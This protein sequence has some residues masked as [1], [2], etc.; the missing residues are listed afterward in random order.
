MLGERD[1]KGTAMISVKQLAHAC[2]LTPDLAAAERFY[3]DVLGLSLTF[4]FT[5]S[6]TRMGFYLAAGGRTFVEFFDNQMAT[7]QPGNAVDHLCFEVESLDD[8]IA[9]I[10]AQGH[11]VTDKSLGCD[12]T[13]QAW[14]ADP[15]GIK[16]EL[17]EYTAGSAQFVGGD[18]EANW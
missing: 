8:A 11:A 4:R 3:R 15:D 9:H 5:R 2:I 10:R 17:F 6:G 16:I 12:E 7:Y 13:W 14:T 18:R 1:L